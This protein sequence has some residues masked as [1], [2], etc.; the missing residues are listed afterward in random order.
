MREHIKSRFGKNW[1]TS[2]KAGNF[3]KE[4]WET[5]ERHTADEMA[6]LIGIGPITFDSLIDEF[7]GLLD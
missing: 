7:V 4:I 3:L 2:R 6:S 5:G 1:W